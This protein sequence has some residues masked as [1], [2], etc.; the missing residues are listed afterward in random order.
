MESWQSDVY[1]EVDLDWLDIRIGVLME[2]CQTILDR[3]G[4]P[5]D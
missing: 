5:A 2:F 3:K 4:M 1:F